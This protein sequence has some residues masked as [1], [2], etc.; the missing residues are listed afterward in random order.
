[1][2]RCRHPNACMT[3]AVNGRCELQDLVQQYS[4]EERAP[5]KRPRAPHIVDDHSSH[6]LSFDMEKCILCERCV[7][8]CS[9]LSDMV[10]RAIARPPLPSQPLAPR[11]PRPAQN[12][13]GITER[14]G[15]AGVST[16][17]GVPIAETE[18][19]S[20]GQCAL[21]CPVGAITEKDHVHEVDALLRRKEVR[22]RPLSEGGGRAPPH[23]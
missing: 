22:V 11:R 12:I 7:R 10:R 6:A 16:A 1:M 4:V 8:A 20:C 18:C 13:L 9:E 15:D 19:I 14:G 3:C 2:L 21:H 23:R 17:F 5:Y